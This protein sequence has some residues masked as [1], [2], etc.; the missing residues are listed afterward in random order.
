MLRKHDRPPR[1]VDGW[2][3]F[4]YL[5]TSYRIN[6]VHNLKGVLCSGKQGLRTST[7]YSEMMGDKGIDDII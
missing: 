3:F 2:R 7:P 5:K 6:Y 4:N 1:A